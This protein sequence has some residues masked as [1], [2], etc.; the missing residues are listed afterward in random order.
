MDALALRDI[1]LP[2]EPGLWP[3]AWGWWLFAC[4]IAL[5]GLGSWWL[6]RRNQQQRRFRLAATLLQEILFNADSDPQQQRI[7]ISKWLRQV[8]ILS[9]GRE[10]VA[11]LTGSAWQQY[12]NA[13]LPDQ[14]F[15]RG[16]GQNLTHV[17]STDSVAEW[18]VKAIHALCLR[19]L[20]LQAKRGGAN[21]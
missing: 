21:V 11:S 13:D 15:T 8:A 10:Q 14:P 3:L 9:A 18:D 16:I 6:L 2:A 4:L 17:Y 19:W 12:L 7:A 20:K 1:H 5:F